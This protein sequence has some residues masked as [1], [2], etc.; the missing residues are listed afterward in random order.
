MFSNDLPELSQNYT[1]HMRAVIQRVSE[2]SVSINGNIKSSIGSGLLVLLGVEDADT[3]EDVSWLSQ[4]ICRLRIM[5]DASGVMN[6]SVEET[7]GDILVISQFT[8]HARTRKGNRPS[9]IG[10]AAPEKAIPLYESY[11]SETE[12]ILGRKVGSGEFGADMKVSLVNNGP[13]TIIIDT[14]NRE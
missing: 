7:G 12:R 8:L 2:A 13:V 4:K 5:S 3:M 1:I 10:A 14:K 6:L 11:I 9:Y